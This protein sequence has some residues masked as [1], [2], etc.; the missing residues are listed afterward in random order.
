VQEETI[1]I[2]SDIDLAIEG[3]ISENDK[4]HIKNDFDLLDIP[5]QID[6]VFKQDIKKQEFLRSIEK[7]GIKFYE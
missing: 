2:G 3:D 7:D 5:Y 4:I 6:I 1:K